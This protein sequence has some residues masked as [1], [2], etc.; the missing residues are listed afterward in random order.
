MLGCLLR[1]D[2]NGCMTKYKLEIPLTVSYL[3]DQI[4]VGDTLSISM[5]LDNTSLADRLVEGR[6]VTFPNFDPFMH[7]YFVSLDSLPIV[8]GFDVHDVI[9]H[10][11]SDAVLINGT[12]LSDILDFSEID[13]SESESKL[14]FDIVLKQRGT[15]VLYAVSMLDD[16]DDAAFLDFPN[17]CGGRCCSR[18]HALV[19]FNSGDDNLH[20]LTEEKKIVEDQYWIEY[21]GER[22]ISVPFYF[23]VE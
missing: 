21:R 12:E 1:D 16:I 7:F 18:L 6:T 10:T 3:E 22:G 23:K 13:K 11:G 2:G 15:F 5:H 20:L 14:G 19:H 17:R 9:V 8:D 4:M